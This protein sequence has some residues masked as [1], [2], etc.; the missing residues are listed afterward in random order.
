MPNIQLLNINDADPKTAQTLNAV[1][2]KI[3]MIPNLFTT[4]AHAPVALD[5]YLQ[6]S[7]TLGSGRLTVRQ[8]EIVALTVAQTNTCEYCLSAH[9]LLGKGAGLNENDIRLARH[10]KADN[11]TDQAISTLAQ[12]IVQI[13]GRLTPKDLQGARSAGLDD[14]LIVEIIANV[15]LNIFTNYTNL[16]ADTDVDFPRV[17][18]AL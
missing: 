12:N 11:P 14:G 18:I 10:G 4:L 16:A 17:S 8:R 1:K 6:F 7:E 2:A 3:G 5:A 9:A 13:R 15:T